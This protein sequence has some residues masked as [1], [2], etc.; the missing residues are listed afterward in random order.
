MMR[1]KQW[2]DFYKLGIRALALFQLYI[3]YLVFT[4]AGFGLETLD[5]SMKAA[6][7]LLL[8]FLTYLL[9]VST[10]EVPLQLKVKVALGCLA[11]GLLPLLINLSELMI[12]NWGYKDV[13]LLS[14]FLIGCGALVNE[15]FKT[16]KK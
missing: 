16:E 10:G 3:A 2:P 6:G 12:G 14:Y 8:V 11:V 9:W 1:T 13:V 7:T 15:Y 4:G 5:V